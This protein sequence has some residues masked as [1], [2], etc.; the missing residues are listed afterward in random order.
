MPLPVKPL[1]TGEVEIEGQKVPIRGLSRR[2]AIAVGQLG[3]DSIDAAEVLILTAGT[4]CTEAE[5]TAW[6]DAVDMVTGSLLIDAIVGLSAM[7]SDGT[8][9]KS[10]TKGN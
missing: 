4:G 2:E 5:A 10:P 7:E 1:P 8:S 9:P 6:R 3:R